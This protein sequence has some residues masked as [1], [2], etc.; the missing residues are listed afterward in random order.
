MNRKGTKH[1]TLDERFYI[2]AA[3]KDNLK[4]KEIAI[5][6]GKSER[7][8]SYEI[9]NIRIL[10][11]NT[12]DDAFVKATNI[13]CKNIL[14]YHFVCNGCKKRSFCRFKEK[15]IY[16][17]KKA[18]NNYEYI[19][20]NSRI[21]LDITENEFIKMDKVIQSGV[22]KGQSIAHI[23]NNN[24]DSIPYSERHVYNLIAN[25]K[26]SV[27]K[28]DLKRA[29]RYAPRKHSNK[30]KES[31]AKIRINRRYSDFL[32]AIA[33][34]PFASVVQ[35]DTV[36]SVRDGQ[37]KCLLT[38]HFVNCKFMLI[39]LLNPKCKSEVTNTFFN[40]QQSLGIEL[41]KKL[42]NI[43]LTDRGSEFVDV[44]TIE[45]NLLTGEKLANV[46]FCDALASW[47]KGAIEKNHE[48]IRE[49]IPKGYIF[50]HLS[51][52]DINKVASHINSVYRPDVDLVPYITFKELFGESTLKKLKIDYVDPNSIILNQSLLR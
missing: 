16:D 9:K 1:L 50:D 3:L 36:E 26:L 43:I 52:E 47:Q 15:A 49:I 18:Q 29:I 33:K 41:Y 19:C 24:K 21:G 10:T 51:Q 14:K 5:N 44:D 39:I 34:T 17:P 6:I 13:S 32:N 40:L 20:T 27:K 4:C 8:I 30:R 23:I 35:M 22:E 12:R 2:A 28:H 11:I 37:H 7:T 42:F 31:V 25:Q 45:C 46:Y 48:F 38:L